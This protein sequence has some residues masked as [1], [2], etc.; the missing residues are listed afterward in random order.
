MQTLFEIGKALV[1][2]DPGIKLLLIVSLIV[3]WAAFWR[4]KARNERMAADRLRE[5]RAD[6]ELLV[7]TVNEA[8]HTVK[9]YKVSNDALKEAVYR[10]ATIV[11]EL[12]DDILK[13][14]PTSGGGK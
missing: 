11:K 7:E 1:G 13:R 5:S 12:R 9:D 14:P 10:I 2:E 4:E 3:G 6:T 8:V